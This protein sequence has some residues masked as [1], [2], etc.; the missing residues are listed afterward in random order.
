MQPIGSQK[1]TKAMRTSNYFWHQ[2]HRLVEQGLG[3]AKFPQASDE[4]SVCL[5]ESVALQLAKAAGV[6]VAQ[7]RIEEVADKR[8]LL[9]KRFDRQG[10]VRIPF[11]SAMSMINAVDNEF[12]SYL[13]I[14]DAIRRYGSCPEE[15]LNELWRRI[16]FSIWIGNTDDHLRNHAFLFDGS[17]WRL[18]P[19]YDINPVPIDVKP[20]VLSLAIDESD[21]T[22]DINLA[23]SVHDY[24]GLTAAKADAIVNSVKGAVTTWRAVA[25]RVGIAANEQNRMAS[26]FLVSKD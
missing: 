18:S 14:A 21:P 15:D 2:V 13:E 16:V 11:M 25:T 4:W 8:V 5:W 20:R 24:F 3:I 17:G 26:A 12:H 9:V 22:G 1:M 23:C 6:N 7:S 19:A 10:E